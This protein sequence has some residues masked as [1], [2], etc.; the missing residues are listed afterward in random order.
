MRESRVGIL[1]DG[2]ADG[3]VG[4]A[5]R[6]C[7]AVGVDPGIA[8]TGIAAVAAGQV[9][10]PSGVG[11]VTFVTRGGKHVRTPK[12]Q[13]RSL[14]R[15]T[16]DAS[17]VGAVAR[18]LAGVLDRLQPA[19]VG[20]E[21]YTVFEPPWVG[22]MQ[23]ASRRLIDATSAVQVLSSGP[24][25]LREAAR[26]DSWCEAWVDGV[27]GLEKHLAASG[28]RGGVGLGQ[29]AKTLAVWG[30]C[31]AICQTRQVPVYV[32]TPG[33]LKQ[34]ALGSRRG[35]KEAVQAWVTDSVSGLGEDLARV[36]RGHQNHVADAAA[37]AVLAIEA[38]GLA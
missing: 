4:G 7:L 14:R 11:P 36:P 25:A 37:L 35:S 24:Q 38:H 16:D 13:A 29:A 9:A 30:A 17:R 19:C 22:Q 5:V 31:L 6:S 27:A 34:R 21:A 8:N 18:T 2:F 10:G 3:V 28:Q 23:A 12:G 26:S 15:G 32:F 1:S 33:D 20:I